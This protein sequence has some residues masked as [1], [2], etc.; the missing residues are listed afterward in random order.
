MQNVKR[1]LFLLSVGLALV[2]AASLM[3][4]TIEAWGSSPATFPISDRRNAASLHSPTGVAVGGVI[5]QSTTWTQAQ[6]PYTLIADVVV[7]NGVTLTVEPGV[8]VRGSHGTQL[9]VRGH[10]EAVGSQPITFTSSA[11]AGPGGWEG[12]VFSGGTGHLVHVV[13]RYAGQNNGLSYSSI[14]VRDVLAGEVRIE[15]CQILSSSHSAYTDYG[16]DVSNSRLVLHDTLL[17]Y[18]GNSGSDAPLRIEAQDLHRADMQGNVFLDNNL[19]RVLITTGSLGGS[20]SL[21]PQ[22]GLDA[23]QLEG[24]I[25]VPAGVT[26]TVEPTIVVMGNNNAHLEVA[27]HLDAV[28]TA[29]QPI[30]FTSAS[31][32]DA[33]RWEGLYFRSGTGHLRYA[34]VRYAGLSDGLVSSGVTVQNVTLGQVLLEN[35][36]IISNSRNSLADYGLYVSNGRVRLASSDVSHNGN[37]TADHGLFA[38]AGSTITVTNG[39]I[40]NNAGTGLTLEDSHAALTCTTI[41]GNIRYGIRL[42]GNG[43]TIWSATSFIHDNAGAGLENLSGSPADVRYNWWGDPAGLIILLSILRGSGMRSVTTCFLPPGIRCRSASSTTLC[44]CRK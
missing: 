31:D 22:S 40:Q 38:T 2:L 23:Y 33:S 17:A 32:S 24:N 26:L 1:Q 30:L 15:S 36:Q 19:D 16:L 43:A 28:G 9:Q 4:A 7:T 10:L 27:G 20:A 35:S 29:S 34:T 14:A 11:N 37:N 21:A 5:T 41:A 39:R 8:Q 44:T 25:V 12:L 42:S 18:L 6:S 3:L 13:V